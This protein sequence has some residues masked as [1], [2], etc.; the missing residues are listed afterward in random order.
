M[1]DEQLKVKVIR[2]L[3]RLE[4]RVGDL[5]ETLNTKIRNNIADIKS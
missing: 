1:P 5:S 3:T 2:I 4:K